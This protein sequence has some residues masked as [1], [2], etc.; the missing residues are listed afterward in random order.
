MNYKEE[1]EKFVIKGFENI[2]PNPNYEK[3]FVL[4]NREDNFITQPK[5]GFGYHIWASSL[6]SSQAFAYNI[7]SGVENAELVF[8]FHM[9][10]FNQ[11]AQIDVKIEKNQTI[12]LYEVKAFEIT[13][14]EHI[15][16]KEKYFTQAEYKRPEIA[17]SFI[18]F[19]YTVTRFF[20]QDNQKIYGG[21]I[22]QL[23][24][25]LLGIINIMNQPIY[26]GKHFKLYSLC[27]DNPFTPRFEQDISRYKTTLSKF[28]RL[29]D[30]FLKSIDIDSRVEYCGFLSAR[31]YISG[32]K[33]ILGKENYEYLANRYFSY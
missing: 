30:D 26:E 27:F 18:Q 14:M 16:F 19:L 21:G 13:K 15:E 4:K 33:E 2:Y 32:N 28:K 10:V 12:E 7:F 17:E 3:S 9:P 6:K 20:E 24:S 31:E 25:H 5:K 11:D 8:E 23:C 1:I 22:K 29:V